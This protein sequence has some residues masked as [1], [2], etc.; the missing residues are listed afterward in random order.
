[1]A[2]TAKTA[3]PGG[4]LKP[5][6]KP[7][8]KVITTKPEAKT[9]KKLP[10]FQIVPMKRRTRYLNMLVYGDYGTG[11]TYLAG[12]CVG[13]PSMNDVLLL[14]AEKGDLTLESDEYDFED[15]D[16]IEVSKYSDVARV[17]DFLKL[18]CKYRDDKSKEA[19]EKLINMQEELTGEEVDDE[20]LRK[21]RT[22]IID[23]LTE[24]EVFCLYDL[25][26]ITD[27]TKLD[28]ELATAEWSEYKRQ[29]QKIQLLM[30]TLRDLPINAIFICSRIHTQDDK[31]RFNYTPAMTGKLAGI[32]QG[33]VDL[34]GFLTVGKATK[35]PDESEGE[36]IIPRRMYVQPV[37]KFNAKC[38][39]S[40]YKLPYFDNPDVEG[41]LKAVG[42]LKPKS[43]EK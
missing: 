16:V 28:E 18:H 31:K 27:T 15:I 10:P 2:A 34:V 4:K 17:V 39:F 24:V 21:Y 13:V 40:S 14:N 26:G 35:D 3:R 30:R 8:A 42:L 32:V 41:I 11:K 7:V 9:V 23:S 25:L 36:V 5:G 33:F 43:K 38:R 22:I 29:T 20:D 37:G 19:H 1:M 6:Q 12:T